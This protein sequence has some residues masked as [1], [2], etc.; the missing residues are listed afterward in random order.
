ML[1]R[2]NEYET[3]EGFYDTRKLLEC[4]QRANVANGVKYVTGELTSF[5]PKSFEEDEDIR[6]FD[7]P[8]YYVNMYASLYTGK[9]I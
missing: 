1:Y 3:C 9:G 2:L 5:K 7:D 4:L 6:P 8:E